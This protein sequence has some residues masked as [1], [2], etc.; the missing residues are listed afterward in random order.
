[1]IISR[2]AEIDR[3]LDAPPAGVRAA[4]IYRPRPR[5]RC[6]SGPTGSPTATHRRSRTIRSTS[7]CSPTPTSTDDPARL[8]G[9]ADG[10]VADRRPP[11]GAPAPLRASARRPTGRPPRRSKRHADGGFNPDAFFLIEAGASAATRRC[12]GPPRRADGA[13]GHR[14]L[15][16]RARRRRADDPRGLA[17]DRLALAPDALELFVSR[18]P[19]ERGVARQEIERLA[20]FLGPG[21]GA[22]ATAER[23]RALPW[24]R[25][26]SLAR[27]RGAGRLRRQARRCAGRA[28]AAPRPKARAGRPPCAR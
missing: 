10:P 28:C 21:S 23:A 9:R 12:A 19:H 3:F 22:T 24:R 18:L 27:R 26:G 13:R 1:M 8:D 4:L 15:R 2:R 25:A 5:G 14:L 6:A 17:K 11:A 20:L 16:G 7:P